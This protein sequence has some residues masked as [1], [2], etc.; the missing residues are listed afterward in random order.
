MYWAEIEIFEMAHD[1]KAPFDRSTDPTDRQGIKVEETEEQRGELIY[2]WNGGGIK[3]PIRTSS[4]TSSSL[5]FLSRLYAHFT[6]WT[7]K[8]D[9][10]REK[11][12]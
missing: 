10:G 6:K 12:D 2:A 5:I 4:S 1:Q 8:R 3:F 11:E 9:R 7:V